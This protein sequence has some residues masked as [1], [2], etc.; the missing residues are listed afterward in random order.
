[1]CR[2]LSGH[3]SGYYAWRRGPISPRERDDRRLLRLLKYSWLE[4]GSVYGH[5]KVTSYLRE[6]HVDAECSYVRPVSTGLTWVLC[7]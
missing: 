7:G 2:A 3:R 4:S 5:R 1:M 6:D